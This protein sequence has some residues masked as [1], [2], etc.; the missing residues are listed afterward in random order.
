MKIKPVAHA[1]MWLPGFG[2]DEDP[3]EVLGTLASSTVAAHEIVQEVQQ[4]AIWPK[5]D[6]MHHASISTPVPKY[7]ANIAAIKLLRKLEQEGRAASSEE[8][9][10]LSL[11]TGWS[12]R[13]M[14]PPATPLGWQ[15]TRN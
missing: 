4:Q 5:L 12:K 8:H 2:P 13:L 1:C 10:I 15:G 9:A 11:Y 7:D 3:I 6:A 14:G